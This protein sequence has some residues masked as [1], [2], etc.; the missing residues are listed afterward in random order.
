ML[1]AS[2]SKFQDMKWSGVNKASKIIE[3]LL[4][5]LSEILT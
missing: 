2:V 5:K 4:S 1:R 3:E